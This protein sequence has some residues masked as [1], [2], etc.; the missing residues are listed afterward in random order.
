[1]LHL[2]SQPRAAEFL[3]GQ[4]KFFSRQ[5]VVLGQPAGRCN[6]L[7]GAASTAR[8]PQQPRSRYFLEK[9]E[10]H[11]ATHDVVHADTVLAATPTCPHCPAARRHR[12][13]ARPA[14]P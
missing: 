8:T 6:P 4:Q 11:D 2:F 14:P 10:H 9:A 1:M 3:A 5:S 12:R 7:P 13:L